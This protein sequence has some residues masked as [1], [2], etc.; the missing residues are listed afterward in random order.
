MIYCIV[1]ITSDLLTAEVPP[2]TKAQIPGAFPE[3]GHRPVPGQKPQ[4]LAWQGILGLPQRNHWTN[5][6]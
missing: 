6:D 3:T 2:S 5:S 4:I 1:D